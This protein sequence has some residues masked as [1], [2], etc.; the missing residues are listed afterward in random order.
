MKHLYFFMTMFV[1][2]I[3]LQAQN[4]AGVDPNFN[5]GS[6][7]NGFVFNLNEQPD[8]KIIAT[9]AFTSYNGTTANGII[10]LNPDGSIDS[11]FNTG[12]GFDNSTLPA[13]I[14]ND[15]KIIVGGIF[16][17]YNGTTANGIIRLN[18]DGSID[19][20]FSTGDGF[21][22]YPLS[23]A[24][25]TDGK[26]IVGG[27]FT[28]YNGVTNNKI[29]RLNPDG[30]MDSGFDTGIGFDTGS[31]DAVYS[32]SLQ[33]D[34]KII[35]SGVFVEYNDEFSQGIA[36]INADGSRDES[37]FVGESGCGF[38]NGLIYVNTLQ[39]DGKIITGGSFEEYGCN[40][41][42]DNINRVN[43]DG[44]VDSTFSG[45]GMGVTDDYEVYALAVQ[46]D[47][48]ILVGGRFSEYNETEVHQFV[49]LNSDGSRD[50]SFDM[51]TGFSWD[52]VGIRAI[53][54][55]QDGRIL[56]GG[57]FNA[58]N[59][60][61]HNNIVCLVGTSELSV[62]DAENDKISFYP[63]PVKDKLTIE[64]PNLKIDYIR[65]LDMN[66]KMLLKQ[67]VNTGKFDVDFSQF[68]NGLY[69]IQFESNGKTIKTE[70]LIKN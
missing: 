58:Y 47:G 44:S 49:R 63:N 1:L 12:S 24:I 69:I 41:T 31:P 3:G 39:P 5:S 13:A 64:N 34:G 35:A 4:Q 61:T 67:N 52:A 43:N 8:G 66:G 26:I 22:D 9:G 20:S 40:D 7:F 62:A 23:I 17:S 37:F 15:G 25:Q 10:R 51:G 70:K 14:Q 29:I 16:T 46:N 57:S 65:I 28:S 11:S 38:G 42:P 6:G 36:R 53:K 21:D 50:N 59:N 54:V 18:P 19:S 32:I 60:E 33:P 45:A 2:C 68:P 48:K 55:L 27:F 30:S 56:I